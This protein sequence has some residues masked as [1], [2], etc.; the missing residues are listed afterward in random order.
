MTAVAELYW[1]PIDEALDAA[2]Y[3]IWRRMRDEAPLYRNERYDFWALSRHADV[4]AAHRDP[5]TFLSSHG[6]VLELMTAEPIPSGM[7]IFQDPPAHTR[8]RSLVSRA[9]TPR[10]VAGLERHVR[11]LCGAL[12][13]PWRDGAD[14]DFVV[15]FGAT[16]PSMVIC[17]L[18]GIPAADRPWVKDRIDTTFHIEP[19]VGMVNDTSLSARIELGDYLTRLMEDRAASPGDDLLSGLAQ[20]DLSLRES[21]EFADLLVSAGTETVARLL[22]WA[23]VVLDEHPDQRADLA[24]DPGLVPNAVEELLRYEAPSPVQGR[25]TGRPVELHG[26]VVPAGS[27]VLLLTGSA[28]RDERAFPDPDRFDVRRRFDQHLSFGYGIHFCLGAS[29]ARLEGRVALEEALRRH[30]SWEVDRDRAVRL[31]TS[32]VRG[33]S[34]VPVR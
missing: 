34:S 20:T 30:P 17:E 13:E 32:T 27:K 5:G 12:L 33:W 3:D 7:M 18:L 19:G 14:F 29:L 11:E 24:A 1:D 8:L 9:F 16:L 28:G 26:T 10:R 2:P 22:G 15:D 23:A 6:T 4:M 21:V 25:W 31:H